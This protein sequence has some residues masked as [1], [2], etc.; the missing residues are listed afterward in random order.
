MNLLK[1]ILYDNLSNVLDTYEDNDAID[2]TQDETK[3][4]FA[5]FIDIQAFLKCSD[6]IIDKKIE[7]SKMRV[8]KPE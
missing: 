6:E 4:R 2:I 1:K 5:V 8:R 7:D 3:T